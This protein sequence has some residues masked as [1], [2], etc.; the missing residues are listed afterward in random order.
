MAFII[1]DSDKFFIGC[2][3]KASE[4]QFTFLATNCEKF[5]L[6]KFSLET[7]LERTEIMNESLR[8]KEKKVVKTILEDAPVSSEISASSEGL[9]I[10]LTFDVNNRHLRLNFVLHECE[11]V[12]QMF[13]VGLIKLAVE[14]SLMLNKLRKAVEAKDVEIDEYKRNGASLV[15]GW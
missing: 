11:D 9:K 12:G 1:K 13:T 5:F 15:R 4:N 10:N 2:F 7:L 3:G 8:F 14:N 6:E